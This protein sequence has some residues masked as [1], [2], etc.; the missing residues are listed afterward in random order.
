MRKMYAK[1]GYAVLMIC[2]VP[3]VS[4]AQNAVLQRVEGVATATK[5]DALEIAGEVFFL[6]GMVV[7]TDVDA[8][9]NHL[10]HLVSGQRLVCTVQETTQGSH[11]TA[12]CL[13][14]EKDISEG[15]VRA[16]VAFAY[17]ENN[18]DFSEAQSLA[19]QEGLGLWARGETSE[20][21]LA[22]ANG[23][24]P[25]RDCLIKGNKGY[26]K[27]YT[28]RYHSPGAAYYSRTRINIHKGESW[29]CSAT[30]AEAAGFTASGK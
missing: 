8:S 16:G 20:Q 21:A 2:L 22:V 5:G 18:L 17:H 6:A 26:E 29:F 19:Q 14:G 10:A 3:A 7:P 9:M 12:S 28:L 13:V 1:T 23:S 27:P 30:S 11:R 4:A 25:P 15:M 24:H